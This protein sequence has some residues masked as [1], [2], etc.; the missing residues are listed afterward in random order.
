MR[1]PASASSL[2]PSRSLD[3]WELFVPRTRTTAAMRSVV[4]LFLNKRRCDELLLHLD[5]FRLLALP[6]GIAFH[7]LLVLRSYHPIFLLPY[8]FSKFVSFLG[9]NRTKSASVGPLRGAI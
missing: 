4:P 6:F 7:H 5:P 2:R 9:A 8:H 1:R 3:R